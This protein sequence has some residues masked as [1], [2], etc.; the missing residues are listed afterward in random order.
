M[1]YLE[2]IAHLATVVGTLIA[3]ASL[4][5]TYL[6]Y[7]KA[8]NIEIVISQKKELFYALTEL[9]NFVVSLRKI[10]D[11][12]VEARAFEQLLSRCIETQKSITENEYSAG[13]ARKLIQ[14]LY[15]N[16]G[17]VNDAWET[18]KEEERD[19]N[20]V[21]TNLMSKYFSKEFDETI[22]KI[23]KKLRW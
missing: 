9:H 21:A 17:H 6:T 22:V 20:D 14:K 4:I 1:C 13:K 2:N 12:Y 7:K 18:G 23:Q 15:Q 19:M 3:I 10:T 5:F 16:I 8:S 11:D